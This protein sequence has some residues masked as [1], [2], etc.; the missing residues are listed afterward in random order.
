MLEAAQAIIERLQSGLPAGV[1]VLSSA[2]YSAARNLSQ[3][4]PAVFLYYQGYRVAEHN[5]SKA[6][7]RIRQTWITLVLARNVASTA[8][9]DAARLDAGLIGLAV[10]QRL[11]GYRPD[12]VASPLALVDAPAAQYQPGLF[13]LPLGWQCD[14]I[15]KA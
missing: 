12:Q 4:A 11:A 1:G 8:S 15:L 14:V 6:L 5:A 10:Y 9:G 3:M 2:D 13:L 7:V